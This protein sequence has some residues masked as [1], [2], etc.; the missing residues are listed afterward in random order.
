M[1]KEIT[2]FEKLVYAACQKIPRGR[3]STYAEIARYI[4]NS[5]S[6][7]AVGN[8]LNRN[9]YAPKVLCHRVVRS[10]GTV[11]GF[12]HGE[13]KKIE[14]LKKENVAI[15]NGRVVDFDKVFCVIQ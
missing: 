4:K 14:I 3:I 2:P 8:A 7:R 11:G 15:K 12:V 9:P 5:K 10:D 1:P 13:K 6:A